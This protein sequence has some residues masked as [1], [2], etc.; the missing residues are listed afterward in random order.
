MDKL[1]EI[2][3]WRDMHHTYATKGVYW[4]AY[5]NALERVVALFEDRKPEYVLA[6]QYFESRDRENEHTNSL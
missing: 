4:M 3:H 2:K 1:K 5:F 6:R